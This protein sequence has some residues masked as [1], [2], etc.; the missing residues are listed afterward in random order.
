MFFSVLNAKYNLI[1]NTNPQMK[2]QS[3]NM[4]MGLFAYSLD[5]HKIR[6]FVLCIL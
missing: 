4:R 3:T 1:C 2:C 5:L 6:R